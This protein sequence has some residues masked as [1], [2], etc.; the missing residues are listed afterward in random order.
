MFRALLQKQFPRI[1]NGFS[2]SLNIH[3]VEGIG[4]I[5]LFIKKKLSTYNY[6]NICMGGRLDVR[7]ISFIY[8]C[9]RG[10]MFCR[11]IERRGIFKTN[12]KCSTKIY[13]VQNSMWHCGVRMFETCKR[14]RSNDNAKD[15]QNTISALRFQTD[16]LRMSAETLNFRLCK[17]VQNVR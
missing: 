17:F 6:Q 5:V 11:R 7:I 4:P 3:D 8:T 14:E 13:V 1:G 10:E 9:V 16:T 2:N 15:E 12:K